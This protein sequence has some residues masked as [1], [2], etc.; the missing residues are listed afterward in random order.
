VATNQ[1]G[2]VQAPAAAGRRNQR[3]N[4]T[5]GVQAPA[6]RGNRPRGAGQGNRPNQGNRAN[7]TN[8]GTQPQQSHRPM[9]KERVVARARRDPTFLKRALKNGH[10]RGMLPWDLLPKD[11][12][13]ARKRFKLSQQ[14]I[15]AGSS[16]TNRQ[17]GQLG[18]TA[19]QAQFGTAE[20]DASNRIWQARQDQANIGS[21]YDQYLA[22]V[23]DYAT[24]SAAQ[25]NQGVAAQ[26]S[27]APGIAGVGAAN[28][29]SLGQAAGQA[30]AQSGVT[31][32]AP[33]TAPL[34]IPADLASTAASS[35]QARQNMMD[36]FTSQQRGIA[37][38][39]NAFTGN[40]ANVVGPAAKV[41]A[42]GQQQR[43]IDT[44]R[45]KLSSL[46]A[47][48]GPFKQKYLQDLRQ[49]EFAN[50]VARTQ[51]NL[52]VAKTTSDINTKAN[53][54]T[55]TDTAT[56]QVDVANAKKAG[57]GLK[58]WQALPP[59]R[60]TR[61]LRALSPSKQATDADKVIT[62]PK[63]PFF[64]LKPSQIPTDPAKR[65]KIIRTFGTAT[66]QPK[67]G[68]TDTVDPVTGK[69]GTPSGLPHVPGLPKGVKPAEAD[70]QRIFSTRVEK[71]RDTI[72]V[73]GGFDSQGGRVGR[74]AELVKALI[75][76]APSGYYV[77]RKDMAS[78]KQ[79]S[80][81]TNPGE[82][83]TA[84][85]NIKDYKHIAGQ[86]ITAIADDLAVKVA[87]DLEDRAQRGV[88]LG[89]INLMRKR[90]LTPGM[91][92]YGLSRRAGLAPGR[93]T[94][95]PPAGRANNPTPP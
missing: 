59:G 28:A 49:Q 86:R 8:R 60:Q 51:L 29:A 92:N 50:A 36:S 43:N 78:G 26:A 32:G 47:T 89:A 23:R 19:V 64:G 91:F 13:Q 72:R 62:D 38:A 40:L 42:L 9:T 53:A 77:R 90:R 4:Q 87:L 66:A 20:A 17:A 10:L 25:Q 16:V 45:G 37:G 85:G 14:P 46:R 30:A 1:T 58:E 52:D 34:P 63:N 69:P 88:S 68:K 94:Q 93:P 70:A 39:Q 80:I 67:P 21:W 2:G 35:A 11:L 79:G 75:R 41:S 33:P 54:P 24:Q 82:A 73:L 61:I 74:R 83:A 15:V 55:P 22:Q 95:R 81:V 5:G 76:G 84:R 31:A 44:E 6:G 3:P 18:N 48:E 7:Q 56:L 57:M 65:A 71:A 27:L 12:Q